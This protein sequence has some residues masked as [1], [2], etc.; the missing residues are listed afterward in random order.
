MS[1][2]L[3]D[4]GIPCTNL[5]GAMSYYRRMNRFRNFSDEEYLFMSC[6]DVVSRGLDTVRVSL[7]FFKGLGFL[8]LFF[9]WNG[10]TKGGECLIKNNFLKVVTNPL[11]K[12]LRVK[13]TKSSE[14]I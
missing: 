12:V 7:T 1:I 8:L 11:K 4:N 3:N 10:M 14:R 6:T 9:K 2:F 13:K 5:N